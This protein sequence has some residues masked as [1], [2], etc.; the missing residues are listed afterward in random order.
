MHMWENQNGSKMRGAREIVSQSSYPLV[1][2][3]HH[4]LMIFSLIE[5]YVKGV[6]YVC[7]VHFVRMYRTYTDAYHSA[8]W[9]AIRAAIP[10]LNCLPPA[11]PLSN[12]K[13]RDPPRIPNKNLVLSPVR[14]ARRCMQAVHP[15]ECGYASCTYI[16][17]LS[18]YRCLFHRRGSPCAGNK[19]YIF[20]SY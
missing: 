9:A 12:P 16:Q 13:P 14:V 4:P 18:T 19:K 10:W 11:V 17:S 6:L 5:E 1:T 2:Q 20:G 7:A 8:S 3:E 15:L